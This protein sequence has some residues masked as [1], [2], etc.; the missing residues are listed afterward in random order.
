MHMKRNYLKL[1]LWV[2]ILIPTLITSCK[3]EEESEETRITITFEDV[4]LASIG[5]KNGSDLTGESKKEYSYGSLVTNYYNKFTCGEIIFHNIYT[6]DWQSWSGFA[7]SS[8]TDTVTAGAKNVYSV[9]SATGATLSNNFMVASNNAEMNFNEG[10][11]KQVYTLRLNNSTYSYKAIA[12]GDDGGAGFCRKFG[13]GDYFSVT[14]TGY[15][16]HG[17]VTNEATYYLADFRD[18]KSYICNEWTIFDISKLGV[19]NKIVITFDSTDKGEYGINTPGYVCID[20]ITYR[21]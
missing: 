20:N 9:Y 18:G 1:L 2:M 14:F 6:Q 12:N 8:L 11:E 15:D 16:V 4:D 17:N 5:Y 10:K 7:C 21:F 3:E 19:V 13:E